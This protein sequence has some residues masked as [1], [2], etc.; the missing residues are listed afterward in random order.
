MFSGHSVERPAKI[1]FCRSDNK[2]TGRRVTHENKPNPGG[3]WYE[4]RQWIQTRANDVR[5][6]VCRYG[7]KNPPALKRSVWDETHT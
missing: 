6:D 5:R 1:Y 7:Y 3:R 4:V 2:Q